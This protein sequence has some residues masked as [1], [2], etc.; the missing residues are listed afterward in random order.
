MGRG[1]QREPRPGQE[2]GVSTEESIARMID[3]GCP[4]RWLRHPTTN[5]TA[6]PIFTTTSKPTG[7]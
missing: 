1:K 5:T 4:K 6:N 7:R 2:R 3:E